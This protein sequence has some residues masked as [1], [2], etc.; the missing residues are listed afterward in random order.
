MSLQSTRF[1]LLNS[2]TPTIKYG[3]NP[4]TMH[5]L[6]RGYVFVPT[7]MRSGAVP[8]AGTALKT[9]QKNTENPKNM[10]HTTVDS[11]VLAPALMPAADS[12]DTNMGG[13]EK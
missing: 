9:G 10:P 3:Q 8:A 2:T 1:T 5:P 12:G 11:P 7:I 13:P 6:Q 4:V